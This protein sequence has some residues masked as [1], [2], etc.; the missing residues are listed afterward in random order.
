MLNK[1]AVFRHLK[2]KE[3]KALLFLL[4]TPGTMIGTVLA[5]SVSGFL[6][7]TGVDNGWPLI[8]YIYGEFLLRIN[9][10]YL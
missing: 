10:S 2:K 5:M 1:V 8:F 4:H 6:C 3:K 7:D 9:L